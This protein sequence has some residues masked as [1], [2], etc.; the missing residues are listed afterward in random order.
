[1]LRSTGPD[2]GLL[3]RHLIPHSHTT[4]NHTGSTG[5]PAA[6]AR[7]RGVAVVRAA[8]VG[9]VVLA[10][11]AS[12]ASS[13]VAQ[14]K[15]DLERAEARATE[16]K[17]YFKSKLYKEA[18]E[19]FMDAY[20]IA[21]R[22][23]LVYNAARA[24]EELADNKRAVALFSMY[25]GLKGVKAD[26][27]RAADKH[28]KA[29]QVKIAAADKAAAEKAAAEKAAADNAAAARAAAARAAADK[30]AADAKRRKKRR[31]SAS[32]GS[33]STGPGSTRVSTGKKLPIVP[34]A[35]A[36]AVGIFAVVAQVTALGHA[37]D[38][39]IANIKKKADASA[40]RESRDAAN[41]WQG[42]A[43][44]AGVV[45]VGLAGW[46]AYEL[47]VAKQSASKSSTKKSAAWRIRPFVATEVGADSPVAGALIRVGL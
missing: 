3:D 27:R 21:K 35:G 17:A 2:A 25:R 31:G 46:A 32:N 9:A 45:A 22:P 34:I 37:D 24:R 5:I 11:V 40:V 36:G 1:M 42:I 28:I 44:G 20:A 30:A 18:A 39:K 4:M 8:V 29:L 23:T 6:R 13:A 43:I 10:I 19:A 16:G 26:G 7:R 12:T 38:A 14:S 47:L 33:G 41:L 15:K